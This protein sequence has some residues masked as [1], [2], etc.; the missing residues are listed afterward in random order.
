MWRIIGSKE[1]QKL[2]LNPKTKTTH[3]EVIKKVRLLQESAAGSKIKKALKHPWAG[4]REECRAVSH[5]AIPL[6]N[7]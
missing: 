1:T 7:A 4:A 6:F 5:V 3:V 2:F